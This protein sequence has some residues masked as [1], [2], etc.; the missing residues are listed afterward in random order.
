MQPMSDGTKKSGVGL[1][2]SLVV[3]ALGSGNAYADAVIRTQAMLASTIAE[4]YVS[5]AELA[6]E[7]EIGLADLETFRNLM[8]DE[9]YEKLGHPA[10]S[11]AERLPTFFQEDF[12]I[13]AADGGALPGRVTEMGPKDRVRR[14]EITG[15]P[16]TPADG[17]VETVIFVRL[18][19]PLEGRPDS[20]TLG[21]S[22][23]TRSAIGF[24]V[25]HDEI[26]VNDFRYLGPRQTLDLDWDDPWYS[27][28]RQ[29]G[30]RRAYYASMS[31][32]L[33]IEPYEVRKEIILR[34][35]DL[36]PWI[37]LGLAGRETI[38]VELQDE[39]KRSVA[40]FLRQ[41]HP[42]R[43]DGEE[44]VPELAQINFL[45][46]TLRT[47]R[48]ID[49]PVELDLDGALLGA[50]FVYPVDGLPQRVTMEWG[51]FNE[52][53]QLIPA[54]AVDQAGPLPTNLEP[55]FN[56]L[57]WTNFLKHPDLP[58]LTV[59]A[60]PP[61]PLTR[62]AHALRWPLLVGAVVLIA[63]SVPTRCAGRCWSGPSS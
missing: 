39:V 43:I 45:E 3:F 59:L 61:S 62:W 29:R 52:R 31:G 48:V 21:G 56:V 14:D 11:L 4:Y 37:D 15:E 33:Y 8:P 38:P 40:E 46:R 22:A 47:S 60:A 55:D 26:A 53:I 23:V 30:L 17:E 10:Q 54:A 24:V 63:W 1:I 6:V 49:P 2:L 34:P 13:L 27:R 19:Y 9:I 25:Y 44:V 32:F 18:E 51:L 36:A 50:I 57:E 7:I 12:V 35:K 16:L 41:H 5:E 42:V 28:F 58:T 20:L